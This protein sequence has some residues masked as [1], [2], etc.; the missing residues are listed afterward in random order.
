MKLL[1]IFTGGTI[2]CT[3][4]NGYIS[5]DNSTTYQLLDLYQKNAKRKDISIESIE[6]YTLLSENLTGNY[7][8]MLGECLENNLN[9]GYDGIIITHG[10]DTIQY[11]AASLDFYLPSLNIPVLL[12]S[13]NLVLDNE[14]ANG[15]INFES[16]VEFIVAKAGNGVYVPYRNNDG[17][18]YIHK[19]TR[20][21]PHLPYCD[22]LVSMGNQY[23]AIYENGKIIKNDKFVSTPVSSE[24]KHA[25]SL[26]TTWDSK[27]KR[28]SPY[29]G[30]EYPNL[31]TDIQAVL[32]DTYH[33]GTLCSLTPN[34]PKFYD[35]AFEKGIP[36][37]LTG[38]QNGLDY[39]SV[40]EWKNAHVYTLPTASPIAMYVKLWMAVSKISNKNFEALQELMS[41]PIAD[42]FLTL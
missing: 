42:E 37:F 10:T 26:P 35:E 23:Y 7:M 33:S 27:I 19:G 25:L 40:K 21:L 12:V 30:M 17:V 14:N 9:K 13:S 36:V 28:I 32:L 41:T 15:L 34:M 24:K 31:S 38:S 2:G 5:T 4:K 20:L 1:V 6:P 8:R 39:E 29:P 16:A 18:L 3:V 11:S 22:D